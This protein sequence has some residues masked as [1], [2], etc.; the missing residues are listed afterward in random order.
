MEAWVT[1]TPPTPVYVEY[2]LQTAKKMLDQVF[3]MLV[4]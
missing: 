1:D 2:G 4:Y 3:S